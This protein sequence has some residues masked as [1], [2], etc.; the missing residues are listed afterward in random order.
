MKKLILLA[1]ISCMLLGSCKQQA[2]SDEQQ[3]QLPVPEMTEEQKQAKEDW[4]NWE[5]L[6]NE[7]KNELL[8][9]QKAA[10]DKMKAAKDEREARKAKFEEAMANWDNLSLDERRAAFDL[11]YPKKATAEKDSCKGNCAKE[12]CK[13]N[14]SNKEGHSCCNHK[15]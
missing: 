11:L 3:I 4:E 14:C 10:Y 1:A 9:Q 13:G 12:G 7:R 2:K 8:D 6:S 15:K 5:S